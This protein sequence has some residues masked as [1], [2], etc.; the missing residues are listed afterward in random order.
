MY[1]QSVGIGQKGTRTI[2]EKRRSLTYRCRAAAGLPV[3]TARPVRAHRRRAAVGAVRVRRLDALVR[4]RNQRRGGGR[5]GRPRAQLRHAAGDHGGRVRVRHGG[6]G[7]VVLLH[8]REAGAVRGARLHQ[9]AAAGV[10]VQE[11][12]RRGGGAL[13]RQLAAREHAG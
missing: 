4:R 11:H 12:E 8:L 9:R 2:L 10:L 3:L 7:R 6:G 13:L 1:I 5:G